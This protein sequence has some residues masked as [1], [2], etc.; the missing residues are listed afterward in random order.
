M[1]VI[2]FTLNQ[3]IIVIFS[4]H[5]FVGGKTIKT[6]ILFPLLLLRIE[7]MTMFQ[8]SVDYTEYVNVDKKKI[9]V[10]HNFQPWH[11]IHCQ[12]SKILTTV[13]LIFFVLFH[14]FVEKLSNCLL[15]SLLEVK[16]IL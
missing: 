6:R 7:I 4:L 8:N 1:V 16:L 12:K 9:L 5:F 14:F 10:M 3:S 11:K 15:I 2:K 13:R